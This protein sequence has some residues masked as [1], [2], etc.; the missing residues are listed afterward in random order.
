MSSWI[1]LLGAI[2]S[3]VIGTV[4]IRLLMTSS[5]VYGYL[6]MYSMIM[7]SYFLL[8]QAVKRIPLGVAYALWEGV[9]IVLITAS[10]AI[11]F[12][13]YVSPY[14]AVGLGIMISG[15]FFLKSGSRYVEAR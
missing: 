6:F 1:Y 15:I 7:L 8:A 5:P 9:G 3:E 4:S 12:R 11:L 13:E 14:K 10:S 2:L